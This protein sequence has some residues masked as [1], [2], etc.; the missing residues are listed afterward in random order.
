MAKPIKSIPELTGEK[1]NKFLEKM[2]RIE[3]SR[4]SDKQKLRAR[5][6]E[7]NMSLLLG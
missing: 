6:I 5:E 1:A 2:I 4:I 7:K 3:N